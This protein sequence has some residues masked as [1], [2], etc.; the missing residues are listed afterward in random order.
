MLSFP[1]TSQER[2]QCIHNLTEKQLYWIP[3]VARCDWK[4]LCKLHL[5]LQWCSAL[6]KVATMSLLQIIKSNRN[7]PIQQDHNVPQKFKMQ[8][9][10][11]LAISQ[12]DCHTLLYI[13]TSIAMTPRS[14]QKW[15]QCFFFFYKLQKAIA[16]NH[17]WTSKIATIHELK[18]SNHKAPL[19]IAGVIMMQC[20]NLYKSK[21][22]TFCK[23]SRARGMT[24]LWMGPWRIPGNARAIAMQ[25]PLWVTRPMQ[26][27]A[28]YEQWAPR[29]DH[30]MQP[31]TAIGN[32]QRWA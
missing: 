21:C 30:R 8:L 17:Q 18:K 20:V 19:C 26:C 10:W 16:M 24:G 2:L 32:M 12:S 29:K 9:W 28:C 7:D 25:H 14:F 6:M 13:A 4:G 27:R 23:L 11:N 31:K 5:Q 3:Q 1:T 22:K 15:P